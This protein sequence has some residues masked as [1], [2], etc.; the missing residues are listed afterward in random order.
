MKTP[1]IHHHVKTPW[2]FAET[3]W[4]PIDRRKFITRPP[5]LSDVSPW[6]WPSGQFV[7]LTFAFNVLA[8]T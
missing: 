4:N 1:L 3:P 5:S 8:L 7:A 2:E 6:P